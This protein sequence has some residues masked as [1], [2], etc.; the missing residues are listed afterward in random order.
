MLVNISLNIPYK[1]Y[2]KAKQFSDAVE[3]YNPY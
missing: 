3:L 1:G 2:P